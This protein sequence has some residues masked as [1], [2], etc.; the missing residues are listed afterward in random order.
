MK[1]RFAG[2]GDRDEDE[3][4][5]EKDERGSKV[6]CGDGSEYGMSSNSCLMFVSIWRRSAATMFGDGGAEGGAIETAL[7]RLPAF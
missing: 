3:D 2:D 6:F 1:S 7:D 4:A 5:E